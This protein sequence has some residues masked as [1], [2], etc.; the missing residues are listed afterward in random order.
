[1]K[2]NISNEIVIYFGYI[3]YTK[4]SMI[5]AMDAPNIIIPWTESQ[6]MY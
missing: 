5:N 6:N 1:M 4:T 2:H 3:F